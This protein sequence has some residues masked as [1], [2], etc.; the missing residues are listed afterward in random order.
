MRL[1]SLLAALMLLVGCNDGE[2]ATPEGPASFSQIYNDLLKPSC[3]AGACHGGDTGI[4]GLNF[5]TEAGAYAALVGAEVT[6]GPARM[7]GYKRVVAGDPSKSFLLRKLRATNDDLTLTGQGA[8]MPLASTQI[9]TETTLQQLEGWIAAG[10]PRASA[11]GNFSVEWTQAPDTI[12]Y[13]QCDATDE[14]GM[15]ACFP[16]P[17]DPDSTLRVYTPPMELQPGTE[18]IFCNFLEI[19]EDTLLVTS[20]GG[21]QMNGGHHAGVFVSVKHEDIGK[22]V[23][24]DDIDMSGLRFVIGAGGAGGLD[25]SLKEGLALRVRKGEQLVIQSHYINVDP[26]PRMVMDAVDIKLTTLEASPTIADSFA[27]IDSEFSV[28]VGAEG[29]TRVKE[30]TMNSDIELHM[31]LGHTH[32][33]GVRFDLEVVRQNEEPWLQYT[34]TDGPTLRDNPEIQS[35]DEPISL[36]AGDKLRMTCAWDN[37]T[38]HVLE[39]PEEMCVTFMYYTPGNG[40]MTCDTQDEFPQVTGAAGAGCQVSTALG[41]NLGVGR[42]CTPDGD[43]CADNGSANFCLA[44]FSDENNYCS[45]ILCTDDADCGDGASCIS[46][47]P[48]SACILDTCPSQ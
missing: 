23:S 37:P 39:W 17:T 36:V 28:P 43:E 42:F 41:N 1:L 12:G 46:E 35:Y 29:Y 48:G 25:T 4:A 19:T 5:A 40:W 45:V 24:C 47:G 21:M 31:L 7:D 22:S 2:T 13:I 34:A 8:R 18:H 9:L 14:A 6:N 15:K 26:T 11:G 10:A 38:E 33:Y 3:T 16:A 20:A 30:C 44:A 32:D 27:M